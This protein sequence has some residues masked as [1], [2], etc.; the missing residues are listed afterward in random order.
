MGSGSVAVDGGLRLCDTAL[1]SR[2]LQ[3]FVDLLS[4]ARQRSRRS[5]SM[6]VTLKL[7]VFSVFIGGGKLVG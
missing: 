2:D 6:V 4:Q 5:R 7:P 1:I 3:S